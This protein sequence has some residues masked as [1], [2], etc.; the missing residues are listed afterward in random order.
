MEAWPLDCKHGQIMEKKLPDIQRSIAV[1]DE[2]K[3][4]KK[5]KKKV[6]YGERK[7]SKLFTSQDSSVET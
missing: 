2:S 6:V 3:K 4:K 5:R 7:V 1:E